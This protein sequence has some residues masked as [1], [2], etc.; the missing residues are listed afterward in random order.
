MS[1][2]LESQGSR[3]KSGIH[4]NAFSEWHIPGNLSWVSERGLI[5]HWSG[6]GYAR[7]LDDGVVNCQRILVDDQGWVARRG[8]GEDH[9]PWTFA[10]T[11]VLDESIS[12]DVTDNGQNE[13][14]GE[15]FQGIIGAHRGNQTLGAMR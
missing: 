11:A 3:K 13:C 9:L 15:M 6:Q 14:H 12:D 7:E 2:H 5:C 10:V 1:E 4:E 8:I